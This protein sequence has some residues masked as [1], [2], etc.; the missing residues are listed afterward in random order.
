MAQNISMD[1]NSFKTMKNPAP[2]R[3]DI[4]AVSWRKTPG[5]KEIA[6]KWAG[7]LRRRGYRIWL[8]CAGSPDD[9]T[10]WDTF[11]VTLSDLSTTFSFIDHRGASF[12]ARFLTDPVKMSDEVDDILIDVEVIEVLT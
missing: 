6:T 1:G 3:Q 2:E 8:E 11:I 5:G 7:V 9:E 4:S 10:I 12:T